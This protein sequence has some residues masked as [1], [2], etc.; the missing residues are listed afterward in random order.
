M[1]IAILSAFF[2]LAATPVPQPDFSFRETRLIPVQ[3]GGRVKP[4]DEFAREVTLGI[5]GKR[6][7]SGWEPTELL[8]SLMLDS[9]AW[10]SEP[11]IK[12]RRDDVRKQLL[13]PLD[14]TDFSVQELMQNPAFLQYADAQSGGVEQ[15]D[16]LGVNAVSKSD[17]RADEVKRTLQKV[18]TF[19]GLVTGDILLLQ[20]K[21]I[22]EAWGSLAAGIKEFNPLTDRFSRLLKSYLD[23]RPDEFSENSKEMRLAS[24]AAM[25]GGVSAERLLQAEV[26]YNKVRPFLQSMILYL[27][28]SLAWMLSR[29]RAPKMKKNY[30]DVA[31]MVAKSLTFV[32]FFIH[33]TGFALRC[34]I[35]GRP[36]VSN[37]YESVI[38]VSFGVLVFAFLLF[39]KFGNTMILTTGTM[40]GGLTLFAADSAP[41]ILDPTIHPLVPVLRSNYWLTI[42]VLTI[43]LSYAAFMLAMGISNITLWKFLKA[44]SPDREKVIQQLNQFSYRSLQFG[45]VLLAAGTILGGVWADESWGRFWG[46]DPKEVW[47][48]IA[49]LAYMAMLHA[50]FSGLV[51]KFGFPLWTVL[52]FS[53]VVMAWYG[54]NF[55]LGVG[56]HSYGF[57]S[58]GQGVVGTFL[59]LQFAYCG[60]VAWHVHRAKTK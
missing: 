56:L 32:A 21:P 25:Q 1:I 5:F 29:P 6:I 54:V 42:H 36:P 37:M 39:K 45:T 59:L 20:P 46:W 47:A 14:R 24:L 10:V 35:S 34:Y 38:W 22:P 7:V 51:G 60:Y 26:V 53:T 4:L 8:I 19:R 13:L 50:R 52:C 31:R 16:S 15:V 43:T 40:L 33:G 55:I 28:A 18:Q 11:I 9:Q 41:V 23:R 3:S 2:S 27:L 49:L 48:L 57:S 30:Q 44:A 12:I 58:G 17:P